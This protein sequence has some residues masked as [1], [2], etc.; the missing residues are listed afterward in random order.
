MR[1]L[2]CLFIKLV[3]RVKAELEPSCLI[4]EVLISNASPYG[5][6][7]QSLVPTFWEMLAMWRVSSLSTMGWC[8]QI[9]PLWGRNCGPCVYSALV[10]LGLFSSLWVCSVIT[11]VI[12]QEHPRPCSQG[13]PGGGSGGGGGDMQMAWKRPHDG[14]LFQRG[15]V[16]W[17]GL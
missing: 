12:T 6:L 3:S 7:K 17:D 11:G 14:V 1:R 9:L 8:R 2:T 15:A 16:G 13:P 10:S 5:F 4:P